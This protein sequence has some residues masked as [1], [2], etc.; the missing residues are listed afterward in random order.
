M[1]PKRRI[2]TLEDEIFIVKNYGKLTF[3][4]M[5]ESLD[6]T[7]NQVNSKLQ[8]LERRG[9]IERINSRAVKD[10]VKI[11]DKEEG[12]NLSDLKLKLGKKYRISIRKKSKKKYEPFFEGTM[13]QDCKTH[14]TFKHR[15]GYR[16]SFLKVDFL[17]GDYKIEEVK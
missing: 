8:Q 16:E 7:I 6:R 4:E 2:W 17:T 10:K 5:A 12:L 9:L 1:K 14:V 11:E 13:I 3:R 15:L